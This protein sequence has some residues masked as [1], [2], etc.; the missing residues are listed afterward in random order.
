M[1]KGIRI[2]VNRSWFIL[3]GLILSFFRLLHAE[4]LIPSSDSRINY[5]GR[6]DFT[7]PD[8]PKCNWS[9]SIIEASFSGPVIGM[10]MEHENS[11]FDIEID[12]KAD[13]VISTGVQKDFIFRK[14]LSDELHT[15]RI[16]FRS[17]K[18]WG[19]S[20]FYGLYLA[21]GNDLAV[22]PVRPLR[23]IEFIG[24]SH[25]AGY[26]IESASRE[27]TA[28]QLNKYTNTNKTFA[29]L[30]T[31]KFYAQSIILGNSGKGLVRN[32]GDSGKR[33][34]E[35]YPWYYTRTLSGY[36]ESKTWNFSSWKPDLVVICLGTNDYSTTPHPDD[37]MYIGAY[38]NFIDSIYSNYPDVQVLCV[39]PGKGYLDP[40]DDNIRHVVEEEVKER[41][42][43]KVFFASYPD[44]ME[45]TGCD[46]HPSIDDNIKIAGVLVDTIM[47]KLGWD[48]MPPVSARVERKNVAQANTRITGR[49]VHGQFE[50][51]AG[52]RSRTEPVMLVNMSGKVLESKLTDA[53]GVCIYNMQK[54]RPGAYFAGNIRVGWISTVKN[55]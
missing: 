31:Q 20:V 53:N 19:T 11:Y 37:S 5:Y 36:Y 34:I 50:I 22:P 33:S 16:K 39:S 15:V 35:P 32:Y 52:N 3:V 40:M 2:M 48:T 42:H 49:L 51:F 44:N 55:H 43:K 38:H 41:N 30:V 26:G 10:K 1:E 8:K 45:N 29:A 28:D 25:T 6:F 4:V 23:K 12:G 9:G 46:W 24:D 14:D 54:Y 17:E 18:H 21:E 47:E 7:E 27:C 13:T